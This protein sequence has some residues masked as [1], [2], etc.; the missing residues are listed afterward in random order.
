LELHPFGL[1]VCFGLLLEI[2]AGVAL[3][4]FA[5]TRV[6]QAH[7]RA[8]SLLSAAAGM[9]LIA[10]TIGCLYIV[11]PFPQNGDGESALVLLDA[12]AITHPITRALSL[13]LVAAAAL[14]WA[15]D[16]HAKRG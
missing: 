14:L 15:R 8:A 1:A 16:R 11:R 9:H 10:V 6:R 13:A 3:L 7:P 5:V 12:L 4:A 2:A